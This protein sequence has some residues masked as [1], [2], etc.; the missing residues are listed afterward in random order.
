MRLTL[1]M[2]SIG[3]KPDQK[4]ITTWQME[5]LVLALLA[6]LT[7]PDWQITI[8]DDRM[9]NINYDH[10]AD[11]VAITIE[12]YTARR[13]YQI[14]E[15][16]QQRGVKVVMGG[17]HATLW[18][19]EV[20]QHADS[21]VIGPAE[22][23]W[24]S[25]LCDAKNGNL[26]KKYI[27]PPLK[28]W[29]SVFPRREVYADKKYLPLALVEFSRGCSFHCSFCSITALSKGK[30]YFRPPSEVA[31]EIRKTGQ[32]T[33]FLIDD[34]IAVNY[35]AA[36]ELCREI[37]PL[38]VKW[39]SQISVDA[40]CRPELIRALADAGCMGLLIG[41]ESLNPGLISRLN[42]KCNGSI[43]AYETALRIV[44]ENGI[45]VYGTFLFGIDGDTPVSFKNTLEFILRHKLFLAAF[46][47]L[48]PFP[49]TPL[50]AKLQAENRLTSKAWWLDENFRF[51]HS[52]FVPTGFSVE[53]LAD[54]CR[55]Y[56]RKFYSFRS[57]IR[58]GLD[59]KANMKTL[60]TSVLFFTQNYF[61]RREVDEKFGLPL[62]I[63][64]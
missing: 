48:V 43:E 38:N 61:G 34:N 31:E 22:E 18:S 33:V 35:D 26:Q 23:I 46:N 20:M 64:E 6:A 59:P 49:G 44:H 51:G 62:G 27:A 1:I 9:E 3:R 7:P 25:V 2:P 28:K 40:A 47:H 30:H 8:Q 55:K 53:E 24:E 54:M 41:F 21:T 10:P 57:I 14:A 12:T 60:A 5:P 58:R 52:P 42:K 4:Y 56:R 63:Q 15:K 16:Y 50:Y 19:D 13:A 29:Q 11:L 45:C 39:V 37:K 32:K 17:Y 36:L